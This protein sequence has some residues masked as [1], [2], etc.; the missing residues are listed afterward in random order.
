MSMF[1]SVTTNRH[2]AG[3]KESQWPRF[4]K[5]LWQTGYRDH[6]IRDDSDFHGRQVYIERNPGRWLEKCESIGK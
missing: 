6:I 1:K 2:V 5:Q 4:S 3:V